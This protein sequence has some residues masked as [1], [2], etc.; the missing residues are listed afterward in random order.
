MESRRFEAKAMD[1]T[2]VV[3]LVWWGVCTRSTNL[4]RMTVNIDREMGIKAKQCI[5]CP[6]SAYTHFL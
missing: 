4:L 6:T 2:D 3:I 1:G 5:C